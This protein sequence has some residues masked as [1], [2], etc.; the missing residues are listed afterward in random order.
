MFPAACPCVCS[1]T[2]PSEERGH[3][4]LCYRHI[5]TAEQ[6]NDSSSFRMKMMSSKETL[7]LL[8]N[9]VKLPGGIFYRGHHFHYKKNNCLV[10]HVFSEL[11]AHTT[12][13]QRCLDCPLSS[14]WEI[15]QRQS[16]SK[17]CTHTES[18]LVC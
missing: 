18:L 1:P 6:I 4:R 13:S 9:T 10:T 12:I 14:Q 7:F 8:E 17:Q 16:T 2:E 15:P 11:T 3:E 5:H